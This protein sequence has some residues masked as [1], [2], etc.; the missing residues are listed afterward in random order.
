M[1]KYKIIAIFACHTTCI[2]KYISTL[3]NINN[4]Y[5]HIE[6]FIIIDSYNQEFALRSAISIAGKDNVVVAAVTSD[7]TDGPTNACG[8]LVDGETIYRCNANGLDPQ[9]SLEKHTSNKFL[10][11]TGDL[12]VSGPTGTNVND[13]MLYITKVK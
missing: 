9:E 11:L 10:E 3:S 13:L 6:K 2:K 4:I 1:N 12:I 5:S 8:G 7:G